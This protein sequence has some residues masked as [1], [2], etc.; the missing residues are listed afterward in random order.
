MA[1]IVPPGPFVLLC[2]VELL[3]V[4]PLISGGEGHLVVDG[5]RVTWRAE[6]RV[7]AW[8]ASSGYHQF[9]RLTG[10]AQ[11]EEAHGEGR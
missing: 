11:L 7:G 4:L 3:G 1:A 9:T 6:S 5:Q 2:A 10:T 8:K